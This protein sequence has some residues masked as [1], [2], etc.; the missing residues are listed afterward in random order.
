[1]NVFVEDLETK[2]VNYLF[3]NKCNTKNVEYVRNFIVY[4]V[5][6]SIVFLYVKEKKQ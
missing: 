4:R 5:F 2:I 1:M 3:D 6:E